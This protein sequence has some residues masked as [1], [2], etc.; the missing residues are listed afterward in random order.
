MDY[1]WESIFSNDA[2][3]SYDS[4][5]HSYNADLTS[6]LLTQDRLDNY[7]KGFFR[8]PS[9]SDALPDTIGWVIYSAAT[10]E[11]FSVKVKVYSL[12]PDSM[13]NNPGVQKFTLVL[14]R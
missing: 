4:T 11:L 12:L 5:E 7:S 13:P 9:L 8:G 14:M 2:S 1:H 10:Y 6:T 3:W